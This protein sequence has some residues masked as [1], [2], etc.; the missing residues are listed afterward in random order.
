MA[1]VTRDVRGIRPLARPH[2][3]RLVPR[4]RCRLSSWMVFVPSSWH[5]CLVRPDGS[6][7][8]NEGHACEGHVH[9]LYLS[10]E[11]GLR[12]SLALNSRCQL[13]VSPGLVLLENGEVD[14]EV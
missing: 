4:W 11:V 6:V 1:K 14:E 2:K 3:P 13:L 10:I 7:V 9:S 12:S 5:W 8:Q